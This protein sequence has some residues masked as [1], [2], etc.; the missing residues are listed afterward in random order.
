MLS[1]VWL[2]ATSWTVARQ[3]PLSMGF[4]RQENWSGLP[5]PWSQCLLNAGECGCARHILDLSCGSVWPPFSISCHPFLVRPLHLCPGTPSWMFSFVS[6][7]LNSIYFLI[8]SLKCDLHLNHLNLTLLSSEIL[9][10]AISPYKTAF[11]IIWLQV[12]IQVLGYI[13]I[14]IILLHNGV[15]A[16]AVQRRESAVCT[17]IFPPSWMFLSFPLHPN[18]LGHPR[19][20]V[21][22]K[23]TTLQCWYQCKLIQL[24]G[25]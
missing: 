18:H 13:I 15:L 20:W 5:F 16:P 7:V 4:S 12:P 6:S 3:T 23:G 9:A 14:I 10:F 21:W 24:H 17:H 2:F 1:C 8:I 22:R 25:K 11:P 19:A